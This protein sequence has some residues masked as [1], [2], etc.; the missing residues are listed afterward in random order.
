MACASIWLL[1][2]SMVRMPSSMH[3]CLISQGKPEL[4]MQ[5]TQE[6]LTKRNHTHQQRQ[7]AN[8]IPAQWCERMPDLNNQA[9][10]RRTWNIRLISQQCLHALVLHDKYGHVK[11]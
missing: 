11:L 6:W 3:I 5:D 2:R 8:A 10:A 1:R 4:T 9:C 7:Q